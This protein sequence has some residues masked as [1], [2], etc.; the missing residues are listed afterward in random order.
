[1]K[2][3]SSINLKNLLLL[4][5]WCFCSEDSLSIVIPKSLASESIA[6]R[7]QEGKKDVENILQQKYSGLGGNRELFDYVLDNIKLRYVESV[8]DK[9]LYENALDGVLSSLDPHSSYMN[10]KEYKEAKIHMAGEFGGVGIVVTKDTFIKVI[11]PI[12]DTPA[13]RAGIKSGDFIGEIN[14]KSTYDMSLS[15]AVENMRGKPGTKVKLSILRKGETEPLNFEL[16]REM[17]KT[18]TMKGR[19]ENN[20]I[21]YMKITH[22]SGNTQQ[23]LINM[24]NKLKK[25]LGDKAPSGCILDLRNNPGGSLD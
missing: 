20:D 9:K 2:Y 1:M 15:D 14:D 12:D 13:Y 11:S 17:I 8:E 6:D 25:S 18:E 16:K 19:L 3:I 10:E 4:L 21:I 23:D 5:T 22:F 7:A 24:F